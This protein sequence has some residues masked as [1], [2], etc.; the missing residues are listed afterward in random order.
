MGGLAQ[1]PAPAGNRSQKSHE[2]L[3]KGSLTHPVFSQE[4]ENAS[5]RDS[6]IQIFIDDPLSVAVSQVLNFYDVFHDFCLRRFAL[7]R[8]PFLFDFN[9]SVCYVF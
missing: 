5:S 3:D 4:A 2:Y 9:T 8:C 1:D 6:E 7:R